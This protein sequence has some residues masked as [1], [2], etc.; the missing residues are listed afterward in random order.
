MK[1]FAKAGMGWRSCLGSA[2]PFPKFGNLHVSLPTSGA[3][4]CMRIWRTTSATPRESVKAVRGRIENRIFYFNDV[5]IATAL[6]EIALGQVDQSPYGVY[7]L[8]KTI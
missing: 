4:A 6:R 7:S 2:N 8:P 3:A 5:D 1:P